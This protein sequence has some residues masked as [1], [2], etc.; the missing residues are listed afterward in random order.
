MSGFEV[1]GLILSLYPVIVDAV[2]LCKKVRSGEII[3]DLLEEVRVEKVIFCGWIQHL[4]VT[5]ISGTNV[6]GI[7]NPASEA[8][9]LWQ[10]SS[11][12]NS[13]LAAHARESAD[14]IIATLKTIHVEL[15][16]VHQELENI[17]PRGVSDT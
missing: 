15:Q 16:H 4:C 6:N 13:L 1:I 5:Q 10:Q 14:S 3:H 17:N 9:A 7:V 11:F 12:L 8:F 2:V